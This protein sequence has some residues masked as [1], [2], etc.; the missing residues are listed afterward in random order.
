MQILLFMWLIPLLPLLV[1]WLTRP[2]EK[3]VVMP[4]ST[5]ASATRVCANTQATAPA[6]QPLPQFSA[7]YR[8]R[9][10][11][12]YQEMQAME[13]EDRRCGPPDAA[14]LVADMG[15]ATPSGHHARHITIVLAH[16]RA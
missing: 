5:P 16:E 7:A 15:N 9:A 12:A 8:Q 14:H 11:C 2:D 10:L 3:P 1:A 13:G 6:R 4:P